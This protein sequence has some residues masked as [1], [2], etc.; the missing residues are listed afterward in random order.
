MPL[1]SDEARKALVSALAGMNE[2][3]NL[4]YFTQDMECGICRETHMFLD[5]FCSLS[6]KLRVSA[7]DFVA[8]K[9]KADYYGVARIPAILVLDKDD[10][11]TGVRFYGPPAG[12]EIKSFLSAI[13]EISNGMR[14]AAA[15]QKRVQAVKG[16]VHIQVFVSLTCPYCPDAV[17]S[18][19]RL[20][21]ANT[22]IHA[23]MI[24]VGVFP[25][26]AIDYDVSGVPKT[27]IN[28]S[29]ELIGAHPAEELVTLVE[30]AA[31]A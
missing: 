19:H 1:I 23:D 16:T 26:V 8:E 7:I 28:G 4:L 11:D 25:H 2:R 5:E 20:A 15:L 18:A 10:R 29:H 3:V 6:D 30:K 27:V 31:G 14:L 12:Y 22:N 13:L 24:D 9:D 17:I 21:M